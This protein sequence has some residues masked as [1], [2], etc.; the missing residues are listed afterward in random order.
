MEFKHKLTFDTTDEVN[1]LFEEGEKEI[2]DL[3]IDVAL[4]NLETSTEEIPVLSIL[5]K[6]E[7]TTY[8]IT[9]DRE[10]LFETL[11]LN[12][13]IMEEYEDYERCQK[14]I[15]SLHNLKSKQ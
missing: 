13:E 5:D 10:D 2:S 14:I 11:E 15:D 9:I 12:L 4:K 7:D 8:E 1:M 3:I 6:E